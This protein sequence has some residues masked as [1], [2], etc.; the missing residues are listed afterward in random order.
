MKV[1]LL[2]VALLMIIASACGTASSYSSTGA[3][4]P[5]PNVVSSLSSITT[6]YGTILASS[7]GHT[8]YMFVP[9]TTG[10]S[11]CYES[12]A[13]VWPPVTGANPIISGGVQKSLVST[14]TRTDG[15]KQVT[16]NGHPLYTYQGDSGPDMINGQGVNSY[17]GYWYVINV[18]GQPV[19]SAASAS[20]STTNPSTGAY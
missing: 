6:K 14:I 18:A 16:Y 3:T 12:C 17:G 19:T 9:D 10:K 5:S 7:D 13:A 8:Y 2:P 15:I 11:A 1:K 4:H 20:A